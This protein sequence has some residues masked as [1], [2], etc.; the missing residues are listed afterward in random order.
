MGNTMGIAQ[1]IDINRR[2]NHNTYQNN[3]IS[4]ANNSYN[5]KNIYR[6]KHISQENNNNLMKKN[7]KPMEISKSP[8]P[9]KP[10]TNYHLISWSQY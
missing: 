9:P 2:N 10:I 6:E 4:R 8:K 1:S 3:N 5:G 7:Y